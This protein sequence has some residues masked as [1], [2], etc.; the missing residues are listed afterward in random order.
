MVGT[1]GMNYCSKCFIEKA[2]ERLM[3]KGGSMLR[4]PVTAS[5]QGGGGGVNVN[6]LQ[7]LKKLF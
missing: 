7:N 5:F 6:L 4:D 1:R 3:L 2:V